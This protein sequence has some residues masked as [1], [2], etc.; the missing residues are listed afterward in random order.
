MNRHDDDRHDVAACDDTTCAY[1]AAYGAGY[2][3]G[4]DKTHEELR[5]GSWRMHVACCGC[6]SCRTVK[7]IA[8]GRIS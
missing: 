5:G 1:C 4:K 7:L 2:A 3:A 6:E 8:V